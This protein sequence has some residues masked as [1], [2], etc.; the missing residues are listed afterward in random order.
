MKS[1]C[2]VADVAL[3]ML[4]SECESCFIDNKE[5][6]RNSECIFLSMEEQ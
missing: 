6:Q 5:Q 2:Q 4:Y 3:D 1:S